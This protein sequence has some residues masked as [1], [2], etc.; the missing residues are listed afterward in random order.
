MMSTLK[1]AEC[2]DGMDT[3]AQLHVTLD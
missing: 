3:H 2:F 1:S